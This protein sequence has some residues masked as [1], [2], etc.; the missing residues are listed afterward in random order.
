MLC[1]IVSIG[2]SLGTHSAK[3]AIDA[4]QK[5]SLDSNTALFRNE[6][7][8]NLLELNSTV[9]NPH[10]L[11]FFQSV[12]NHYLFIAKMFLN[13]EYAN[14]R[15]LINYMGHSLSIMEEYLSEKRVRK[16]SITYQLIHL[17]F[18]GL[19]QLCFSVLE[20]NRENFG[21]G[22]EMDRTALD[23]FTK[24]ANMKFPESHSQLKYDVN[25]LLNQLFVQ[26]IQYGR[27]F[28]RRLNKSLTF[29]EADSK[30][31]ARCSSGKSPKI[32]SAKR[33]R[34]SESDHGGP[35]FRSEDVNSSVNPHKTAQTE[36]HI[37]S[38]EALAGGK[39]VVSQ[40]VVPSIKVQN[41]Q[42]TVCFPAITHTDFSKI[43]PADTS[44]SEESMVRNHESSTSDNSSNPLGSLK[45]EQGESTISSL[46]EL[47]FKHFCEDVATAYD[48]P[49]LSPMVWL[50]EYKFFESF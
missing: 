42:N 3:A 38:E 26:S 36:R 22:F 4:S 31:K 30:S 47:D 44:R 39:R 49:P 11:D 1:C 12:Y 45:P 5:S 50:D 46:E 2:L 28:S 40:S 32:R 27:M 33:A 19:K 6:V 13:P 48:F 10:I 7:D 25:N 15:D 24:F 23:Y 37:P 29:E 14:D 21:I 41:T 35:R 9:L 43:E 20:K 8:K 16:S 18:S 17:T 34:L